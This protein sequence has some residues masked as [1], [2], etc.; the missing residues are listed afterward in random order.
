MFAFVFLASPA[1]KNIWGTGGEAELSAKGGDSLL[2]KCETASTM[3]TKVTWYKDDKPLSVQLY[4]SKTIL[5][6]KK[7]SLDDFG[8]YK[9]KAENPLGVQARKIKVINGE[10]ERKRVPI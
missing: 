4:P 1:L 10:N 9:C 6:I 2:L 7:V 8:V 5:D 3:D